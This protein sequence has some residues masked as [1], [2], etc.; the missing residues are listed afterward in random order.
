MAR[1]SSTFWDTLKTRFSSFGSEKREIVPSTDVARICDA[2]DFG[3]PVDNHTALKNTAF[4]AGIRL[5]AEN[6]ASLPKTIRTSTDRG[7]V[8]AINHHGYSLI[9]IRPNRYTNSSTF[10]STMVT[11]VKGWGNAYAIIKRD[12]A[13]NPIEMHQVHPSHVR[14]KLV[15]GRKW[16]QVTVADPEF[17]FLNGVY[18]DDD[19]IHIMEVTLDGVHGVNPIIYNAAALGKSLAIEK[20]VAE[21]YRKGGNIR[22]VMETDGS[23]GDDEYANFTKHMKH[24]AGN[25]ETPLLEYGIKYKQLAVDPVAEKLVE[26]EILSLQDICRILNVPPHMIA[27]LS[28]AT[29]SNIEHQTIQFVQYS[30]RP[31]I[32]RIE[33]ELESKLFF[34]SEQGKFDVKFIL[35]GLLRG[36]TAARSAYYHNAILDGYMSR[37]EVRELEGMTKV[38]GLDDYLYPTNEGIVGKEENND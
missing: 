12:T 25:Y 16:Y 14:V 33:T 19:M 21:F 1:E 38:D 17:N 9:A 6:V 32:K 7:W 22:A 36:D 11:W 3:V 30:L 31:I 5:I 20:F 24:A 34:E 10:W 18:S 28:R 35:D 23:L 15:K 4:F 8:D 2:L 13:G 37:N 29:F 27:D 26:S